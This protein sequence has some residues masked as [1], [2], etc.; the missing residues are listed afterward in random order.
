MRE[1][2]HKE[3]PVKPEISVTARVDEDGALHLRLPDIHA[4]IRSVGRER[5]GLPLLLRVEVTAAEERA[6]LDALHGARS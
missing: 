2:Y 5:A 4:R 3:S 6:I 1:R